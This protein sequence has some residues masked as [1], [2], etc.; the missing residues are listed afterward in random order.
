MKDIKSSII[1]F[2]LATCMFLLMGATT[3]NDNATGKY[4]YQEGVLLDTQTGV[5]WSSFN[6]ETRNGYKPIYF[7]FKQDLPNG[8]EAIP[9]TEYG[10]KYHEIYKVATDKALKNASKKW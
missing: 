3:H 7:S 1:G 8:K 9:V 10:K 4:A 5:Y 6:L 2:L